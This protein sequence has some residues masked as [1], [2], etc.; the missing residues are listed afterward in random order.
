MITVEMINAT[1]KA[2]TTPAN[3]AIQHPMQSYTDI[4]I[5]DPRR[6]RMRMEFGILPSPYQYRD[7]ISNSVT[8]GKRSIFFGTVGRFW[9]DTGSSYE[10]DLYILS[11]EGRR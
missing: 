7:G 5:T 3:D 11:A 2:S 6:R 10:S 8:R 4:R 1:R 9:K